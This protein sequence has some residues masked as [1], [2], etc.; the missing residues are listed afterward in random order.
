MLDKIYNIEQLTKDDIRE[1]EHILWS[2]LGTK[3]DYERYTQGMPFAYNVAA[4]IRI[5]IGIDRKE[6]VRKFG[7]FI[8][9]VQ[10]NSDQEEFL[11][12]ILQYVCEN[13]DITKD[14]VVNET[15]F[16]ERLNVF[17]AYMLPLASYVDTLH[18]VIT[19][20]NSYGDF[21]SLPS[22]AAES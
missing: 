19:P 16:D 7:D 13:G 11:M 18:T 5:L 22:M 12:T 8:S 6:A 21:S 14:I 2:E 3:D 10:L 4:F 1:L 9:G 15:P 17:T 20:I